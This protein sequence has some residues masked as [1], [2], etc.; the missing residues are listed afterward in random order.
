MK[1]RDYQIDAVR[2]IRKAFS[3][4]H[5]VLLVM[6]TGGGK[7][8]TFSYIAKEMNRKGKSVMILVHRRELLRQ[9]SQSLTECG[10]K[11]GLVR[12]GEDSAQSRVMVASVQ[13]LIRRLDKF[14]AP[15]LLII[16][17]AHHAV[18]GSWKT[19]AER[20]KK[21]KIL[22]VTATPCR[23]DGK[24]LN[25]SF[26]CM[27]ESLNTATLIN[28]GMLSKFKSYVMPELLDMSEI[29]TKKGDFDA[30]EVEKALSQYKLH[31]DVIELYNKYLKGETA[32]A[33]CA[34]VG[35]ARLVARDFNANGIKAECIDGN[36][37]TSERDRRIKLLGMGRI[38][39]LTSCEIISEGT[40]IPR[41]GGALLLRPTMSLGLY[42]QQVGR[43]LRLFPGKD[44]SFIVDAVGNI[45]RHG[46]PDIDRT[47]S[48]ESGQPEPKKNSTHPMN[49]CPFCFALMKNPL[50]HK[51]AKPKKKE[52]QIIEIKVNDLREV[53]SYARE[54]EIR[55]LERF[56]PKDQKQS[57]QELRRKALEQIQLENG[58]DSLWVSRVMMQQGEI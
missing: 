21:S 2:K 20:F 16:D 40:D 26:D 30:K 15:D 14:E 39:V 23:C 46:L 9:C 11:H 32:I 10:V 17:E 45:A 7:T 3:E 36:L 24:A 48:L 34:T 31:F 44:Y 1:L 41:V 28:R 55:T 6:P 57:L 50:T 53:E 4:H 52:K 19:V 38:Q 51:C 25:E 22:G 5:R 12:A 18:A 49:P 8:F 37:S 43:V 33:F 29:R 56:S 54:S 58:H 47:W 42:L 27:I 13:T 35:H